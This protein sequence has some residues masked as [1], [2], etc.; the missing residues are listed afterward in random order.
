MVLIKSQ[1]AKKW[2]TEPVAWVSPDPSQMRRYPSD[3]LPLWIKLERENQNVKKLSFAGEVQE[4]ERVLLE[5]LAAMLKNRPLSLLEN[6]SL[7][8]CEAFLRDRNSELALEGLDSAHE[9]KF[10]KLFSWL[11]ILPVEAPAQEYHFSSQKPFHQLKLVDKVRELKAFLNSHE[12]LELYQETRRPEL[13][14][15]D[16]MTVYIQAP[17]HSERDRALF[18]ELHVLGVSTFQE[19]ELNFIPEA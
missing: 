15:I 19:E 12:V 1:R 5:A 2:L 16:E 18:E 9:A 13:V 14:D 10:K 3:E 17:Y 11:R 8:E 7:R 4:Y 6:L